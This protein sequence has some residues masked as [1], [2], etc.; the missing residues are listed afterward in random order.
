MDG[1]G[2]IWDYVTGKLYF[3]PG[4]ALGHRLL[5]PLPE[6]GPIQITAEGGVGARIDE[7]GE[8]YYIG[9]L[10]EDELEVFLA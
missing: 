4:S 3:E 1:D 6:G 7:S 2:S 5:E 10:E 8:S 9:S